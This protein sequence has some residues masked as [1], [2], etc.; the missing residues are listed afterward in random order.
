MSKK[1]S[2]IDLADLEDNINK[3]F[4][5]GTF[6]KPKDSPIDGIDKLSTGS[7]KID[8]ALGG[9]MPFG[10]IVEI[11]G[12][13]ASGKTSLTLQIMAQ[14][15][16]LGHPVAF[17]DA[18]H[19]LDLEYAARL[20]V[21]ADNV[22]ISQ[23]DCG[24][25]ALEIVDAIVKDGQI[26][27]IVVDSVAALVPKKE[28]EGEM[29]DSVTFDT[30]IYVRDKKTK[31]L[32]I[33]PIAS[34]YGGSKKFNG[35]RY[36]NRYLKTKSL[37]V[38]THEGWRNL[39]AVFYKRNKKEK[40]I[41]LTQTRNGYVKTTPDHCLFVD[42]KECTAGELKIGTK[43][44][45]V[46]SPITNDKDYY[47]EDIAFLLGAWMG[48]GA[49]CNLGKD[50]IN[51][52]YQYSTIYES[53]A[54]RIKTMLENS[55]EVTAT[56]KKTKGVGDRADLYVVRTTSDS[57]LQ[58]FL[59]GV[60]CEKT[61]LRKVPKW[62]LNAHRN[63][64]EFFIEGFFQ[65]DGSHHSA[66]KTRKYYN[67]GLS[68]VAGVQYLLKNI[69]KDSYVTFSEK[70]YEQ[71]TLSET[72]IQKDEN[73]VR[74]IINTKHV[75]EFIYDICTEAGTF[76]T[77]LGNIVLHNSSMGLHARLMSQA[78]RKITGSIGKANCLVIMINQVRSK[79]GVVYGNP[80]VTTGGNA[81]KFYSSQRLEV[82]RKADATLKDKNGDLLGHIFKVKVAKNKIAPPFRTAECTLIYGEGVSRKEEIV[83]YA[84]ELGILDKTGAWYAY[85]GAKIAQGKANLRQFLEDNPEVLT[86][87]EVK[88]KEKL[89]EDA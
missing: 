27:V 40:E 45:I 77:A 84:V 19:A 37:E 66:I 38:L 70:R 22:Y 17:I 26:K 86:E 56:I 14:A 72:E 41:I 28:L 85:E 57:I 74:R 50:N 55:F 48:D 15:Q 52:Y 4:G 21:D 39:E 47:G 3:R 35:K 34:L 75:P 68:V 73:G 76:V 44:D 42:G 30:P 62:I 10:R 67:N 58:K 88:V 9:G 64:K 33:V 59:K 43:L 79:I 49:L 78:C 18:E 71:L 20:G 46:D 13:S 81:L 65:A 53:L 16:K 25:D 31:L 6:F 5:K 63:V 36:V 12:P 89:K 7:I 11:Y 82:R 29:G 32:E 80:E 23:P 2:I 24:E 69:G 51:K 1:T 8:K 61:G 54:K 60:Y 87:L 83:D